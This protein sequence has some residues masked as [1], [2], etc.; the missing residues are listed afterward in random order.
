MFDKIT[1]KDNRKI[2]DTAKLISSAKYRRETGLF[3]LEGMR[4]CCDA[5]Q[6]G[7]KIKALF[8]TD[9]AAIHYEDKVAS[10]KECA[11]EYYTVSNE[12]FAKISETV[13]PQGIVAVCEMPDVEQNKLNIN[14]KG[15]YVA[16]ENISDPSNLGAIS[17]TAEALGVSGMILIGGCCDPFGPKSQR[18]SMGSLLRLPLFRFENI[19]EAHGLLTKAQL[20]LIASV[21]DKDADSVTE[22][23]FVDGDV[24][25]IGNEGNG[26]TDEAKRLCQKRVTIPIVG[27]AESFNAA[28]A[29]AILM[30]ELIK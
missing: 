22:F 9:D 16:C 4:L 21:V 1:G 6:C 26:L 25:I 12:V 27:R 23:E 10:L 7:I 14:R 24:V 19:D 29:A 11:D 17:R 18:A 3:V 28:A 15:R 5:A 13:S 8:F 30:W 2:K 20:R